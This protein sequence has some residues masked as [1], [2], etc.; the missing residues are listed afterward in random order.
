MTTSPGSF[1]SVFSVGFAC[2]AMAAAVLNW[3]CSV[4][5]FNYALASLALSFKWSRR[6]QQARAHRSAGRVTSQRGP[7][8]S[9]VGG[10]WRAGPTS[11]ATDQ[12]S[13]KTELPDTVGLPQ[14]AG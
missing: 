4:R 7:G 2:C 13:T 3:G 8:T 14:L 10:V 5:E 1:R 12:K 11:S 9:C 6:E